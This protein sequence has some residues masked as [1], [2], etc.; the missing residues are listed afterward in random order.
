[1]TRLTRPEMFEQ[2]E[3]LHALR[4]G[5]WHFVPD[6][7]SGPRRSA[8]DLGVVTVPAGTET[9]QQDGTPYDPVEVRVVVS[10]YPRTGKAEHG[11]V[12]DGWQYEMFVVDVAPD[13][14]PASEAVAQYF[15][16]T[17]QEN[18]FAQEDREAG[19]DRIFSY[20]LPGQEFATVIGLWVWNL[21]L[22]RGFELDPPP[23]LRPAQEPYVPEIDDRVAAGDASAP[24]DMMSVERLALEPGQSDPGPGDRAPLAPSPAE[25]AVQDAPSGPASTAPEPPR[26]APPHPPALPSDDTASAAPGSTSEA[27]EDALTDELGRIDWSH[28]LRNHPGWSWDP[29]TGHLH[30]TDGRELVL[31]TVRKGEHA[32]GCTHIIFRRPTGG[33][34]LC[35]TRS[36]CF[37]STRPHASKHIELSVPT[38]VASNLRE[39]LRA[40]RLARQQVKA[41]PRTRTAK[42][43]RPGFPIAPLPPAFPLL[44][45]LPAL[46]L[47]AVARQLLR[48]AA[49]SITLAVTVL[50]A[51]SVP[52]RPVLIAQSIADKQHRRKTWQQHFDRYA[53]DHRTQVSI[54]IAGGDDLRRLLQPPQEEPMT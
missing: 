31:T 35:N 11:R 51:P 3:V 27:A 53:L 34:E 15:G 19:L 17:G 36:G 33:C 44:A 7:L 46:F 24:A 43:R 8:L 40:Q 32:S 47:P 10:R 23:A 45:V 52:T 37:K 38:Q 29:G 9:V 2:A 5:T 4:T 39:L 25:S 20:H 49:S 12:I 13:A 41:R 6:S 1:M 54:D 16:R 26:V 48:T 22:V 14:L 28:A 21:R 42:R 18:R 30:C 50:A